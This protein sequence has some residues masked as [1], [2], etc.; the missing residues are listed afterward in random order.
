MID[1]G[2]T[3]SDAYVGNVSGNCYSGNYNTTWLVSPSTYNGVT[4]NN[5]KYWTLSINAT[6]Y[7]NFA[8]LYGNS[9]TNY[10]GYYLNTD[11]IGTNNSNY[12]EDVLVSAASDCNNTRDFGFTT[13]TATPDLQ[14]TNLTTSLSGSAQNGVSFTAT[15]T[16]TN[17]G[18]LAIAS[19]T[20]MKIKFTFVNK[21]TQ[22]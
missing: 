14:V 12:P 17:N 20:R 7:Y 4:D 11:Y 2:G 6:S 1:G 3:P 21:F 13:Y 8:S 10:N 5:K 9:N 16:I 15:A 19:G 22:A 18:V